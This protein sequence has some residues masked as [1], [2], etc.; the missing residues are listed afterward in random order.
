MVYFAP[1]NYGAKL[2]DQFVAAMLQDRIEA[3]LRAFQGGMIP[4]PPPTGTGDDRGLRSDPARDPVTIFDLL[5]S[6]QIIRCATP[7]TIRQ[8]DKMVQKNRYVR[9]GS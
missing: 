2:C 5:E 4:A 6:C 9:V 7:R 8:V 1:G 3:R